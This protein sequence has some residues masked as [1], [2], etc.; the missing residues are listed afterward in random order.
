MQKITSM[1]FC[2]FLPLMVFAQAKDASRFFLSGRAAYQDRAYTIAIRLFDR[3]LM[4]DPFGEYADDAAYYR[5]LSYYEDERY[6]R[7]VQLFNQFL[8]FYPHSPYREHI[9]YLLVEASYQTKQ[10]DRVIQQGTLFLRNYPEGEYRDD[11]HYLLGSVYLI[12]GK[13]GS[14]VEEFASVVNDTNSSLREIAAYRLGLSYF[15]DGNYRQAREKMQAF[16]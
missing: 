2:V 10:W 15:Y 11:I 13:Y 3:V 9:A 7:S 1:F 5:A 16:L 6:Q 14:A 8:S 12:Q 4:L